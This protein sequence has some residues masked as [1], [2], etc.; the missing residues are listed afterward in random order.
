MN[1]GS[2]ITTRSR[3]EA[4]QAN[5]SASIILSWSREGGSEPVSSTPVSAPPNWIGYAEEERGARE[6]I[7]SE[8][9]VSFHDRFVL[10]RSITIGGYAP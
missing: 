9:A 5:G 1:D 2:S 3:T 4:G 10:T 7:V 8:N 6:T